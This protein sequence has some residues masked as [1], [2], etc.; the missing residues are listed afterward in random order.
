[1]ISDVYMC[2]TCGHETLQPIRKMPGTPWVSLGLLVPFVLPG[3]I[4][5]IWRIAMR[6]PVCPRCGSPALI[7][8]DAPLARTWRAAG[9]IA[10]TP[11]AMPSEDRFERIEQAIDAMAVE[12]ERMR[13]QPSQ[14]RAGEHGDRDLR[15][16]GPTTPA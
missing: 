13:V 11:A 5:Q 10:G 12:I 7:P 3:V 15:L 9:W 4:Y 14:L 1:M 2:T 6:R 16:R 8:G